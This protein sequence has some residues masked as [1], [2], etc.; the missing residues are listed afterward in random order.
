VL[1]ELTRY[2]FRTLYTGIEELKGYEEKFGKV[3]MS[4]HHYS[5]SRV[6]PPARTD[7]LEW[8]TEN[9]QRVSHGEQNVPLRKDLSIQNL[10]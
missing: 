6:D 9:M 2:G 3:N 1:E 8:I 4:L 10:T 7:L 5:E